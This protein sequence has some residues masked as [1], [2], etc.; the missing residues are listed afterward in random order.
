[1]LSKFGTCKKCM[2]LTAAGLAGSLIAYGAAVFAGVEMLRFPAML[3][4]AFFAAWSLMHLAGYVVNGKREVKKGCGSCSKSFALTR[5]GFMGAAAWLLASLG[6]KGVAAR[7]VQPEVTKLDG[8]ERINAVKR[9]LKSRDVRNALSFI[10]SKGWKIDETKAEAVLHRLKEGE[11]LAAG[12]PVSEKAVLVYYEYPSG[13]KIKSEARVYVLNKDRA[14]LEFISVNGID[15]R[16]LTACYHECQSSSDC[17]EFRLCYEYCCDVN[18]TNVVNCCGRCL[19]SCY[20]GPNPGCLLC[21]IVFC[22]FCLSQSG[23]DEWGSMCID[24]PNV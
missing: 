19:S 15:A 6:M 1:M 3:A 22:P 14:K 2:F 21:L 4:V 17:G 12:F 13:T 9:A 11:V 8:L 10:R 23:C 5:R 24:Y 20:S 18:W 16:T 7:I